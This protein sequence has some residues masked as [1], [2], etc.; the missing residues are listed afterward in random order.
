MR[1]LTALL[2]LLTLPLAAAGPADTAEV[3]HVAVLGQ[4]VPV[5]FGP[6]MGMS[7]PLERVVFSTFEVPPEYEALQV[8]RTRH[9]VGAV[10][11]VDAWMT[12]HA[13]DG[14]EFLLNSGILLSG[15]FCAPHPVC[16]LTSPPTAWIPRQDGMWRMELSGLAVGRTTF[17]VFGR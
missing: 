16:D 5:T 17:T 10:A 2:A 7:P 14:Q 12:L 8:Q 9:V 15:A 1:A 4:E 6:W 13:P 11:E 3:F